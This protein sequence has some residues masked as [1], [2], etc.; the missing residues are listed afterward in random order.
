[1][2]FEPV[3]CCD[4]LLCSR[5]FALNVFCELRVLNDWYLFNFIR[6]PLPL[7]GLVTYGLVTALS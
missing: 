7:V 3:S 5:I 6:E 1:M 4:S 2:F